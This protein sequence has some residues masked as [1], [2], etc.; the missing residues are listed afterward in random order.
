MICPS[1]SRTKQEVTIR[2]HPG[3][4]WREGG[5]TLRSF[6]RG[7]CRAAEP[8]LCSR[9]RGASKGGRQGVGLARGPCAATLPEF[10]FR[11]GLG[12]RRRGRP[13]TIA[14]GRPELIRKRR[15]PRWPDS[16][17]HREADVERDTEKESKRLESWESPVVPRAIIKMCSPGSASK[18]APSPATSIHLRPAADS[19]SPQ[20]RSACA[21][22]A[23]SNRPRKTQRSGGRGGGRER[24][25]RN[26]G[27]TTQRLV[28]RKKKG[29]KTLG[30]Y[31]ELHRMWSLES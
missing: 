15:K 29:G 25:G 28:Q 22:C 27:Q 6:G 10:H 23:V 9:G 3:Y 1:P 30:A 4:R 11:F 19:L 2:T 17:C 16:T 5:T 8:G 12:R 13:G 20:R 14:A 31:H 24:G 21:R 18:L 7:R 26:L